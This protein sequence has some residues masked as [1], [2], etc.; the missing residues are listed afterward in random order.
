VK[1][2]GEVSYHKGKLKKSET[3]VTTFHQTQG[4]H[5][6]RIHPVKPERMKMTSGEK[7]QNGK[8]KQKR[9]KEGKKGT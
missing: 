8:A 2:V 9:D 1:E 7:K 6:P 5:T 3:Q 4:H